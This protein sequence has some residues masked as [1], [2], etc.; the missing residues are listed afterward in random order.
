MRVRMD[1]PTPRLPW[2]FLR[3]RMHR[4]RG[5]RWYT[6]AGPSRRSPP[7]LSI[8]AGCGGGGSEHRPRRVSHPLRRAR[9]RRSTRPSNPSNS[10]AQQLGGVAGTALGARAMPSAARP[11][12]QSAAAA[13][14]QSRRSHRRRAPA[15]PRLSSSP[16]ARLRPGSRSS[17]TPSQAPGSARPRYL[18]S[19]VRFSTPSIYAQ[20]MFRGEGE[21][22]R[23]RAL[24]EGSDWALLGT[25]TGSEASIPG[26]QLALGVAESTADAGISSDGRGWFRTSDLSRVKRA[27]SR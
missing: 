3:E 17:A 13:R 11:S 10:D 9:S 1:P 27:L 18:R 20:A 8:A 25:D 12:R 19:R 21:R 5:H 15:E 4:M 22:D 16:R 26:E 24:V 6:V 2:A 7:A 14:T 23:L